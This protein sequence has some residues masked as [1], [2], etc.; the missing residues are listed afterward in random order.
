MAGHEMEIHM[1]HRIA[2]VFALAVCGVATGAD[3]PRSYADAEA[4][5]RNSRERTEYQSYL[6]E[7]AQYNNSLRLDERDGCYS[8]TAGPVNLMLVISRVDADG[9]ATV[10]RVFFDVDNAK[11]RCFER[12]YTGL[13]TKLPPFLP[14]VLQ[15]GMG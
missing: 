2:V 5:W 7:F 6:A 9:F 10:E 12:S 1:I 13:R 8:L 3:A 14:F 11:A 15:L 4:I